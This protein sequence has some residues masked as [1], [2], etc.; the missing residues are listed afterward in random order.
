M[1]IRGRDNTIDSLHTDRV[2]RAVVG[3]SR[4]RKDDVEDSHVWAS[5]VVSIGSHR[6]RLVEQLRTPCAIRCIGGGADGK[7]KDL[8]DELVVIVVDDVETTT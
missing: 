1:G 6:R 3:S 2:E 5:R 7:A 4:A 8:V